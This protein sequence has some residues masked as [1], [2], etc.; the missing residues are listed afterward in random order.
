MIISVTF[1]K[2]S[3]QCTG[4]FGRNYLRIKI[5]SAGKSSDEMYFAEFFTETQVFHER[6]NVEELD[7]F[8]DKHGGKTF[9]NCVIRTENEEITLLANRHGKITRLSKKLI[10]QKNCAESSDTNIEKNNY[11][12]ALSA[13]KNASATSCRTKSGFC[14][15]RA[16]NYIL[17]EGEPIPFLVLL[18]IMTDEGKVIAS[19]YAKFRQINRFLEFVDDIL[20]RVLGKIHVSS[21]RPLRIADF[22]C[23]KS[24][25]TFAVYHFLRNIKKI[26]AE[27]IGLDFKKDV[28]EFC[29]K[30][31]KQ[32]DFSGL[33]F[34]TGNIENYSYADLPD[35][36][37]TLHACDTATDFALEYAVKNY[38]TAILSVPCCQ[39]ELNSQLDKNAAR[40]KRTYAR[41]EAQVFAPLL[42]YGIIKERFS[43]L[44]TDALRAQYLESSG[45][46]VQLL[47]FIDMEHTP[48]NIL[49]RA[50]KDDSDNIELKEKSLKEAG[51]L[52]DALFLEPALKRLLKF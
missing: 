14:N 19:K 23:G 29:T 48:K 31:A 39:H 37:I 24:Y 44:L 17:Q 7:A 3:P 40:R 30:T 2:P 49:I 34:D 15:N 36:V 45:Y 22:G 27:I 33:K 16:K 10:P 52:T 38:C 35:I 5:K 18:G 4:E 13:V 21:E 51:A 50:V 20:P 42:K 28:I 1:S 47:E 43:A 32:L 26:N 11:G 46:S 12:T 25:L 6:L 9:K 8:I 41:T